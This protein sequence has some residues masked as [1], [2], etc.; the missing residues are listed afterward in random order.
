MGGRI[1]NLELQVGG[2]RVLG[3][4][5]ASPGCHPWSLPA[6]S[7]DT[8]G[9]SRNRSPLPWGEGGP[10]PAFSPAGAGRVRGYFRRQVEMLCPA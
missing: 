3:T 2:R 7:A 5:D 4:A 9:R 1:L 10:R 8:G 6:S